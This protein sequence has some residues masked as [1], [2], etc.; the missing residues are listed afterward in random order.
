M[1]TFANEGI[2][3]TFEHKGKKY[4]LRYL[5]QGIKDAFVDW[6]KWQA[7]SSVLALRGKIDPRVWNDAWNSVIRDIASG[8]YTYHSYL[9]DQ[10]LSTPGGTIALSALMFQCSIQE[11]EMLMLERTDDVRT[12]IDR[13]AAEAQSIELEKKSEKPEQVTT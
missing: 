2:P 5:D 8:A 4:T 12:L 10:A 7:Q 9:T 3:L 11:M 13:L 1:A 6:L